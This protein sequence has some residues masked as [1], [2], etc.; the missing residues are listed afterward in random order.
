MFLKS[1]ILNEHLSVSKDEIELVLGY[2]ENSIPDHFSEIISNIISELPSKCD[3][4][5][6]YRITDINR[7]N[8]QREIIPV[9][10]HYFNTKSI[11]TRQFREADKTALFACTIGDGM[12]KWAQQC[13]VI[14]DISTSYFIDTI[15]SQV[16]EN[17]AD[18]LHDHIEKTM[19]EDNLKI[20]NRYSPGYCNWPVSEQHILFSLLPEN[21]CG[22]K[23]TESALMLPVKSISGIIGIGK[24]VSFSEYSCNQCG[25]QDCT[26]RSYLIRTNKKNS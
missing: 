10:E 22:I 9:D 24:D 26:Y 8:I 14:G 17:V 25:V 15:A 16:V 2:P 11:V 21:F 20:T 13:T 6:G 19:S 23:L 18:L 4:K 7:D 12:E 3:I 1:E 5:A